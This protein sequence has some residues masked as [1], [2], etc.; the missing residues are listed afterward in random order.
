MNFERLI[1]F[2]QSNGVLL[3]LIALHLSGCCGWKDYD[4]T[5]F[6]PRK[7]MEKV[8]TKLS[9]RSDKLSWN[10]REG[11]W[12][13]G[14]A[15]A[16]IAKTAIYNT[17]HL[18]GV[19]KVEVTFKSGLRDQGI[20]LADSRFIA[21]GSRVEFDWEYEL[22]PYEG[23][24]INTFEVLAPTVSEIVETI[25]EVAVPCIKRCNTCENPGC[26]D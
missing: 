12:L 18:D 25:E 4:S 9:Y 2:F 3:V 19:F 16:I 21:S 14:V 7:K 17:S 1:S 23:V 24:N 22:E 6:E 5:C 26:D 15:P 20:T 11:A 13:L 8:E 10:R